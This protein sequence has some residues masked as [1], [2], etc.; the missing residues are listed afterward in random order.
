MS[1]NAIMPL[2]DYQNACDAIREKTGTTDLIKSGEMAEKIMSISGGGG[3]SEPTPTTYIAAEFV[4]KVP[5][6]SSY[7]MADWG[8]GK[9]YTADDATFNGTISHKYVIYNTGKSALT[10][11]LLYNNSDGKNAASGTE[12][13]TDNITIAPGDHATFKIKTTFV[14]GVTTLDESNQYTAT[15]TQLRIRIGITFAAAEEGNK[16]IV[17]SADEKTDDWFITSYSKDSAWT[18]TLLTKE[19]IVPTGGGIDYD[20]LWDTFQDNGN[21]KSYQN[22]FSGQT[23]SWTDELYNPKYPIYCDGSS[24][25]TANQTFFNSELTDIKVPVTI[26]GTRFDNTFAYCA[27]LKRIPSLT[28]NN[29]LR[30]QNP[31]QNCKSLEVLNLYGTV[32]HDLNLSYSPKL[33]HDSLMSVINALKDFS[34]L[35]TVFKGTLDIDTISVLDLYTINEGETYFLTFKSADFDGAISS[36]FD[37]TPAVVQPMNIEGIGEIIGAH[38]ETSF[39]ADDNYTYNIDLFRNGFDEEFTNLGFFCERR[40]IKNLKTGEIQLY[41]FVDD[42]MTIKKRGTAT[43]TRTLTIGATNL[44][45]L[46]DAEKVQATEKGWTLL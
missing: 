35:D 13:K 23:L 44:A 11:K 43:E 22:A 42:R 1:K 5:S 12:A 4:E 18:K 37:D 3:G 15:L 46:T 28:L 36:I 17:A 32:E 38:Y 6:T 45:K 24:T 41:G 31:F 20:L 8:E 39:W 21:R 7:A 29:L 2:S 26:E 34:T 16:F 19:Q 33:T 40:Y 14:N 9:L 10:A 27:Y 30:I 25:S